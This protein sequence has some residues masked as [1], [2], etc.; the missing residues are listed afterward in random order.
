MLIGR[1]HTDPRH[2]RVEA[3]PPPGPTQRIPKDDTTVSH[4]EDLTPAHTDHIGAT[5]FSV[6]SALAGH[7]QV[8]FCHDIRTNLRAIIAIHSTARGPALGGTRFHAY[9]REPDALRDVLN[10]RA[11]CPTR[12]PWPGSTSAAARR[13]S[14]VDP[15]TDKTPELLRAYGRFVQ[16]LDGRYYTACDVGT[17]SEDMDVIA[18]GVPLRDRAHGRAGWGR[19]LLGAHGVRRVPGHACRRRGDLGHSHPARP[20]GRRRRRRQGRPPPRRAPARGRRRGRRHRRLRS[21]PS[22]RSLD[23]HPEVRTV[24][25]T[26]DAGRVSRSTSTPPARSATPSPTRW[27]RCSA[28]RV[29]CGAANNQLAHPGVEKQLADRGILYAPDYVVNAGGLIQVADELHGF[30]FERARA[31]GQPRSSTPPARC[32]RWPRP[33]ASRLRSPP[34]ASPSSGWPDDRA[35]SAGSGCPDAERALTRAPSRVRQSARCAG[36]SREVES[37]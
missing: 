11:G 20:H 3:R 26:D 10:L 25:D 12:R 36:Q 22:T 33:T 4:V 16:S 27:S 18:R 17:Y 5:S 19:R 24:A 30:D 13:S 9:P 37:E 28:A 35:A 2:P 15:H 7:E 8:V 34:T 21:R 1:G 29:V 32:S 6:F 31:A 23:A 14:S